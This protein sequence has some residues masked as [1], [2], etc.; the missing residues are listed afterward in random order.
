MKHALAFALASV[1]L[2]AVVHAGDTSE[3]DQIRSRYNTAIEHATAPI[4]Q[5]YLAELEKLRDTYTRASKL[6]AA[7]VVQ[8]EITNIKQASAFARAAK[9]LPLKSP[10]N[11]EAPAAIPQPYW[12]AGKSWFTDAKTKWSF[13]RNGTGEKIRGK[14]RIAIFTWKLLPSGNVELTERAA[15]DK[16]ETTTYV[17]FKTKSEAWFGTSEDQ[18]V[19]RLHV[20]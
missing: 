2:F 20:E 14:D 9:Q 6:E 18:L 11:P 13:A 8:A 12:F 5:N 4:T 17:Q 16:P 10:T 1:F 3:F 7:N 19:N 15:P